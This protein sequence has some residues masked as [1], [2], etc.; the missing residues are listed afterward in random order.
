MYP[1]GISIATPGDNLSFYCVP[2][3]SHNVV[4]IQWLLN[5]TVLLQNTTFQNV[6]AI[7]HREDGIGLLQL[8]E[9]TASFNQTVF[10]CTLVLSSGVTIP[11]RESDTATVILLHGELTFIWLA[12]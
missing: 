10:S 6:E 7:F 3:S 1:R 5:N 9:I 12:I 11:S 8:T 4:D 2:F